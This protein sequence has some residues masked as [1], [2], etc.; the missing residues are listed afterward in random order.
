MTRKTKTALA[1]GAVVAVEIVAWWWM[2]AHQACMH[3]LG[4]LVAFL[5]AVVLAPLIWLAVYEEGDGNG[6][7]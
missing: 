5:T 2:L 3:P 4:N 1:T 7:E 6:G